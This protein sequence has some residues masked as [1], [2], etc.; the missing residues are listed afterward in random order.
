MKTRDKI[1]NEALKLFNEKSFD[2]VSAL[3]ISQSLGMSYGNLTYH[4]KK[5]EDIILVLYQEM[6]E[7]LNTAMANVVQSLFEET[8]HLKL[9]IQLFEI[10]WKYRF[11]YLGLSSLMS[12]YE[13]ISITEK[14]NSESRARILDKAK[15]YLIRE[16]FLKDNINIDYDLMIRNLSLILY[17]W[18]MDAKLFYSGDESKKIDY[19]AKLFF[20]VAIPSLTDKG[21]K[22]LK[23]LQETV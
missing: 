11:I 1:L 19:Y 15:D 3:Q 2:Q 7:E 6:Q 10:T 16:D 9:I 4:F 5:K 18:I 22:Y 13:E 23:E 20:N 21:L 14:K 8:F 17:S 12:Q